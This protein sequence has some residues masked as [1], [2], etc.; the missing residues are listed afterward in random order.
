MDDNTCIKC[1]DVLSSDFICPDCCSDLIGK[2]ALLR[3]DGKN[4]EADEIEDF[5]KPSPELAG[6]IF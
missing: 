5:L 6:D 1:N 2:I 4:H 3:K